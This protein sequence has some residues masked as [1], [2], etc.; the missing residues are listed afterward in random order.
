[1]HR[2]RTV[3]LS[4]GCLGVV[5]LMTGGGTHV[6]PRG[7]QDPPVLNHL[8]LYLDSLSYDALLGTPEVSSQF[9]ATREALVSDLTE[10]WRGL[11]FFGERTYLEVFRAGRG[12]PA[13]GSVALAFGNERAGSVRVMAASLRGSDGQPLRVVT[14]R[15]VLGADTVPWFDQLLP[16]PADSAAIAPTVRWW[17]ME[18]DRHYVARRGDPDGEGRID[19]ATYLRPLYRSDRALRDLVGVTVRLAPPVLA[20]LRSQLAVL[21]MRATPVGDGARLSA[22]GFRVDLLP[23]S[24]GRDAGAET[25]T[26]STDPAAPPYGYVHT[27]N[28]ELRVAGGGT[29]VLRLGASRGVDPAAR[30]P[31]DYGVAKL[32]DRTIAVCRGGTGGPLVV[33]VSG[34]GDGMDSWLPVLDSVRRFARVLAYDRSGIGDSPPVAELRTAGRIARELD[35]LLAVLD[36]KGPVIV[37]GHS[38]GGLYVR[39]FAAQTKVPVRGALLLDPTPASFADSQRVILGDSGFRAFRERVAG[40]LRGGALAE[41]QGLDASAAEAGRSAWPTLAAATL[42]SS[43]RL[44]SGDPKLGPRIKTVWLALHD[45]EAEALHARHVVLAEAGHYIHRDAPEQVLGEL[46]RI[47]QASDRP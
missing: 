47:I 8:S 33:F 9:A 4:L 7:T 3:P 40:Q 34:L 21:G 1:M 20:A 15:R 36:E 37:V 5:A 39:A 28:A 18:Y 30:C 6:A 16:S 42:F 17:V 13:A 12:T 31:L 43:G 10:R 29:A 46:R 23:T 45:A 35:E 38:L 41:W 14:R 2:F 24:A 27:V 25:V 26:F 32:K 11:Y 22:E 44:G 19:R